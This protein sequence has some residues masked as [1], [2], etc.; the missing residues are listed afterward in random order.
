MIAG[1]ADNYYWGALMGPIVLV[2]LAFAPDALKALK[3]AAL[4]VPPGRS[5]ALS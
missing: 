1:R 4:P 3:A 2:G 5:P